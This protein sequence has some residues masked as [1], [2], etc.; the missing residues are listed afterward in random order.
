MIINMA[1]KTF[2]AID[3]GSYEL[4]MKIYE[5]STK[6]GIKQIDHIR[7]K[8][9]LGTDSYFT[10]K[11]SNDRVDELCRLLGE[12]TE[13]MKSYKVDDCKAYGTSAIRETQ[14]SIILLDQI[15]TRTGI[16][17]EVLSNS[18]QRFLDYKSVA[19][20][21]RDFQ[22][23]I[24]KSTAFVDI[25][26]GSIQIS[27]FDEDSL[28]TSQNIRPGVLRM[29]EEL[30][31]VSYKS[32]QLEDIVEEMVCDSLESFKEMFIHD[33]KIQN[34]ILVDDYVSL[35]LQR[36]YLETNKRGHVNTETFLQFV[37]TLKKK[38]TQE[39]A[40]SLGLA[41]ENIALLNLSALMIKHLVKILGA[42][43]LWAP[44]VCLCDGMAYEYA[45]NNKLLASDADG[46]SHDFEQ[47]IL[48]CARDINRRYQ[49][50]EH[51]T[52]EREKIAL[53][54][55]DSLE[56]KHGLSKRDRLLLQLAAILSECGRYIS[57][58]NA[59]ESSYNI[60]LAT[61]IIGLSHLERA[62]VANLVRYST[63]TF[64]YHEVLGRVTKLDKTSYL[65][66]AKLTAIIRLAEGLDLSHKGKFDNLN[67]S[68]ESDTLI[69][70]IETN[71]D[72]T[73]EFG[74]FGRYATFFEEVY[75][76]KP[77]IRQKKSN[78]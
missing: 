52:R 66:I 18:E 41:Q 11:I 4:A 17:I 60:I 13:I 69:L 3:V 53:N 40:L 30:T 37:D 44:G 62:I 76:I 2:A 59:A 33:K 10:G 56:K 58:S 20:K 39:I 14:N 27:L 19:S 43:M 29:R 1:Y 34:I 78:I 35:I 63:E 28:V 48:D 70:H 50:V 5:I 71:A 22:N 49:S 16:R 72:M 9:E 47:D 24:E 68:I 51:R 65:R 7:H 32:H 31:R 67:V 21:G 55:F 38:K 36:D 45:E 12:F 54:I 77:V 8:I 61:E 64:E 23:I 46:V 73:L 25:G 75:N 15:Q 74:L 57:L 26:G 6:N 42:E